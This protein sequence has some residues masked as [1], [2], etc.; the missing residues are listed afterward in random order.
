MAWLYWRTG[1]SLLLTML[2]H[3]SINNTVDL[4]PSAVPGATEAFSWQGGP[5]AW[6]A[7]VVAWI[8]AMAL[9]GDLR[10]G[11]RDVWPLRNSAAEG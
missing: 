6:A 4:V 9:L 10:G 11:R 2:M 8:G 5:T 3:A 1:G 7:V